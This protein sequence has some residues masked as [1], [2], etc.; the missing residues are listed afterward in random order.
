MKEMLRYGFILSIICMVSAGTLSGINA[1][2]KAKIIA[3]AQ[4]EEE[5][6]LKEVMPEAENF[7]AVKS[8]E[9]I[10]Y[11]QALDKDKKV[12][13]I[14]F[15]ATGKG[16]SSA[17]ETMV[18]M[19]LGGKINAI[20]VLSQNETPGLGSGVAEDK[21]S[22]QFK[23]NDASALR[24]VQAITGATISSQAVINSIKKKAQEIQ[25]LLKE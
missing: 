13:G 15:K 10:L 22:R 7:L 4:A 24:E 16:Y 9:K 19:M 3:Q 2:T 25:E 11:Y 23:G 18:G 6:S 1:L 5:S 17:I 20:K 21:F 8:G 12:V 14:V